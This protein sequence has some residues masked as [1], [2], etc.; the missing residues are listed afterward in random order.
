MLSPEDP[1]GLGKGTDRSENVKD[2]FSERVLSLHHDNC[3]PGFL[4]TRLG[5]LLKSASAAKRTGHGGVGNTDCVYESFP[6]N[7]SSVSTQ[8]IVRVGWLIEAT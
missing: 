5:V 1:G 8:V 2:A 4:I 7:Y 6:S 3:A